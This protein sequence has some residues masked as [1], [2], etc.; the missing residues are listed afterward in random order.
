MTSKTILRE[1]LRESVSSVLPIAVIV[2]VMCFSIVRVTTDLMLSFI[3]GTIL[4]MLGMGLFTLGSEKSMTLIGSY[5]GA[6]MTKSRKPA[7][8]K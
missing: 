1:K 4:L 3:V 7:D 6:R 2:A 5:I 8:K